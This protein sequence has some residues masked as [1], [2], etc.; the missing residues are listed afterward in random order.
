LSTI[1]VS[2]ENK[3]DVEKVQSIAT[4]NKIFVIDFKDIDMED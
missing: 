1:L 3:K 4:Q 2:V